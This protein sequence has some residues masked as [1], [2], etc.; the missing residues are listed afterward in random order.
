MIRGFFI[1]RGEMT[2]ENDCDLLRKKMTDK[3]L[4][5]LGISKPPRIAFKLEF[6]DSDNEACQVPRSDQSHLFQ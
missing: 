2:S 4:R 3:Y 5:E 1:G 6:H